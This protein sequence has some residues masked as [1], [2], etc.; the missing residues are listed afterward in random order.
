M[1]ELVNALFVMCPSILELDDSPEFYDAASSGKD[2]HVKLEDNF[3]DKEIKKHKGNFLF[4]LNSFFC[5][6]P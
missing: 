3:I 4:L 6:H 2:N 1:F 5:I